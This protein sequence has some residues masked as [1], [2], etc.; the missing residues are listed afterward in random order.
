VKRGPI[1]GAAVLFALAIPVVVAARG[2]DLFFQG[3]PSNAQ[4]TV[5][6]IAE[7]VSTN[8]NDWQPVPEIRQ[9]TDLSLNITPPNPLYLSVDLNAGKAQVRLVDSTGDTVVPSSVLFSG[10]G[11]STATFVTLDDG[12][13][14]PVIEWKRKGNDR[15]EAASVI[16]STSGE[17]D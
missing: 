13:D 9:G 14:D 7:E 15:V 17:Q 12:L 8:S 6:G 4:E 3:V 16:A 10:K 1:I 5:W 11:V 2:S